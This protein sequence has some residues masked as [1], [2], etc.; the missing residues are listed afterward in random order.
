MGI[1]QLCQPAQTSFR[2][3]TPLLKHLLNSLLV[4]PLNPQFL[5]PPH[6]LGRALPQEG[7]DPANHDSAPPSAEKLLFK[8]YVYVRPPYVYFASSVQGAEVGF[9]VSESNSF[10]EKPEETGPWTESGVVSP[11]P[12]PCGKVS[13]WAI[14]TKSEHL[15]WPFQVRPS[16]PI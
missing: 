9:P 6:P 14:L 2:E 3:T 8:E 12:G 4:P 13:P 10:R 1:N 7:H 15:V 5:G 11:S 16:F